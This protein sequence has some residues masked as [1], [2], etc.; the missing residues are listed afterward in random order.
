MTLK[1]YEAVFILDE[2][3][4]EDG[5]KAFAEEF[6]KFVAESQGTVD[7]TLAMGRKQFAREIR[8]RKSGIYWDFVFTMAPA[9]AAVLR[10]HY[11]L[12]ERLV[13][14]QVFHYDRPEGPIAMPQEE[15]S[16][17]EGRGDRDRDD[18]GDR[19]DRGDREDRED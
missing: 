14:L 12:D 4:V 13:R 10:D 16:D 6:G 2:R 5:G 8:K 11:R 1:K 9:Q 19:G 17:R 15:R 7:E 18:R 3:K